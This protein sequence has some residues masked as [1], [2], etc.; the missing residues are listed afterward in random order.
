MLLHRKIS[1]AERRFLLDGL[2]QGMRVDGRGCFDY[3][4]VAFDT[5]TVPSATGS[6]RLRAGETDL[7]VA[8]KCDMAKPS[9]A[10]PDAGDLRVSVDCAASVSVSLGLDGRDAD[11]YG[12]QLSVILESL[13][14]GDNVVDR[15]AL[16]I[17][18]GLFAWEVHVDVM[19]LASGGNLL[20]AAT[21]A[22][23]AAL[24]ETVLPK[25]EIV[26]AMEEGEMVQLK[27]D[28]RPEVGT[29][30]PLQ[31]LPL[32]VTVAQVKDQFLIDVTNEEKMCAD[33]S[34][35]VV[36][37]ARKGDV[38]GLQKLG[39]GMFDV[40]TLPSMLERCRA[41]AAALM[42]QLEREQTASMN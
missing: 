2:A 29:P 20:D 13:C 15:G 24:G 32:C 16:C 17:V 23:C 1:E 12:R 39:R 7:I 14:A 26:E 28:D 6:C 31:R 21:L 27:V 36:V 35:C 22:L 9:R 30:I 37:D 11:D 42:Q 25:V 33:A 18:P 3:R 19:V 34:I 10:R 4:R 41:A 5:G 8:I 38:I 40:A